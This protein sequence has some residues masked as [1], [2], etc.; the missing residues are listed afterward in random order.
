MKKEFF[1][2]LIHSLLWSLIFLIALPLLIVHLFDVNPSQIILLTVTGILF[3]I[4]GILICLRAMYVLAKK[5]GTTTLAFKAKGIVKED[6]Y[7][8]VRNPIY[9]GVILILIGETLIFPSL[10]MLLYTLTLF[11]SLHLWL[12]FVEEPFLQKNFG[13]EFEEYKRKVPRWCFKLRKT[14]A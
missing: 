12:I 8:R 1:I 2:S 5:K 14:S 6:I 3:I 9:V 11:L 13:K 4:S 7:S 10:Y